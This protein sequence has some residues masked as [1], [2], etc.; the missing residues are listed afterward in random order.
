M[1]KLTDTTPKSMLPIAGKPILEYKLEALPDDVDE[2]ILVVSYLGS[3]IQKHFGGLSNGKRILYVEQETLKGTADA[4][5][6]AKDLLKGKFL[7]MNGDD[8]YSKEDTER[9]MKHAW[10]ILVHEGDAKRA[11]GR[12]VVDKSHHVTAIEEGAHH[13]EGK[14][15]VN[16]GLYFL[17]ERIFN[18]SPLPK[19]K[20]SD[21]LGLPQTMMQA[22]K[23]VPIEVV[24]ATQWIQITAPGDLKK[25]EEIL[26]KK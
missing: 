21:E 24:K 26:A 3:V 23:D 9:C 1:G 6:L 15:L 17:D 8:I 13:G 2:V 16:T 12:V 14:I 11:G 5:W 22:V 19:E 4:L 20:G 7:V 18:Y 25:A 10:T